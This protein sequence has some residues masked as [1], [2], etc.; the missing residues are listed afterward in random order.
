MYRRMIAIIKAQTKFLVVVWETEREYIG[1]KIGICHHPVG[2]NWN[3]DIQW[4]CATGFIIYDSL[5]TKCKIV[6]HHPSDLKQ[7]KWDSISNME[8]ENLLFLS[9]MQQSGVS[10]CFT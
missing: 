7:R 9:E 6:P 1:W 2:E 8:L 5:E 4:P 3:S 10:R